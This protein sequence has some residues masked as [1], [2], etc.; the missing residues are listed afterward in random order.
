MCKGWTKG[1]GAPSSCMVGEARPLRT[2]WSQQ[3]ACC[4][5]AHAMAMAMPA[6]QPCVRSQPNHALVLALPPAGPTPLPCATDPSAPRPPTPPHPAPVPAPSASGSLAPAAAA[7]GGGPGA[8]RPRQQRPHPS[9]RDPGAPAGHGRNG[10]HDGLN[11][12]LA[13]TWPRGRGRG[14]GLRTRVV[15][16]P[17]QISCCGSGP[18][19]ACCPWAPRPSGAQGGGLGRRF[20]RCI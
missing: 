13:W 1:G 11:P 18:A 2:P 16:R 14:R 15:V 8:G 17:Q 10:V 6:A 4:S 5:S 20:R 19:P 9:A 7:N 12:S 3:P